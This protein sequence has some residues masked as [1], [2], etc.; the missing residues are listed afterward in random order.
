MSPALPKK[1]RR[2]RK[3][4]SKDYQVEIPPEIPAKGKQVPQLGVATVFFPRVNQWTTLEPNFWQATF[5]KKKVGTWSLIQVFLCLL[6][7]PWVPGF[8]SGT[9]ERRPLQ[10]FKHQ[11]GGK[12]T[13]S[14]CLVKRFFLVGVYD[15]FGYFQTRIFIYVY[16]SYKNF[17][18]CLCSS[19]QR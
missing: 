2:Y 5:Q 12:K 7:S 13:R 18:F 14:R 17:S 6:F 4:R 8:T 11:M 3:K 1:E 10:W 15:S 16:F 9:K 19:Y